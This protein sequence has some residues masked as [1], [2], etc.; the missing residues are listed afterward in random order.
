MDG[1]AFVSTHHW[2][3]GRMTLMLGSSQTRD[4]INIRKPIWLNTMTCSTCPCSAKRR[5]LSPPCQVSNS[6]GSQY[7]A[8]LPRLSP[9]DVWKSRTLVIGS[10]TTAINIIAQQWLN[11]IGCRPCSAIQV[12]LFLCW[13]QPSLQQLWVTMDGHAS[14]STHHCM[15]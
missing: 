1:P 2:M 3:S 9:L 5:C 15:F 12:I 10:T 13:P 7:K 6:C 4:Q 11:V 8:M 14:A